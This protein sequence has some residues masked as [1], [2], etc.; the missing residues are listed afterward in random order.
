MFNNLEHGAELYY[1]ITKPIYPESWL[2]YIHWQAYFVIV[3]IDLAVIGFVVN[4][5]T[6]DSKA[7]AWLLF[8]INCIFWDVLTEMATTHY[9]DVERISLL[10]AK[11]FF[12]AAFSYLIHKV[13]TLYFEKVNGFSS[14]EQ[15]LAQNYQNVAALEQERANLKQAEALINHANSKLEQNESTINKQV[16]EIATLRDQVFG[17]GHK[18]IKIESELTCPVC[19]EFVADYSEGIHKAI[20][21]LN[22]H[23]GVCKGGKHE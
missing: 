9:K 17:I 11:V 5:K 14:L 19:E 2:P 1:R 6:K 18:I 15:V 13:S 10:I 21:S 22:A 8:L 23:K 7:F 3:V 20:K 4:G 12:S 16:E